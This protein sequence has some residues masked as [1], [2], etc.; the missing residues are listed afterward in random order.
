MAAHGGQRAQPRD[1]QPADNHAD[2]PAANGAE[3]CPLR[4]QHVGE[5]AVRSAYL[6]RVRRDDAHRAASVR[7]DRWVPPSGSCPCCGDRARYSTAVL[8]SSIYASSKLARCAAS[9]VKGMPASDMIV[10]MRSGER[11]EIVSTSGPE[12]AA[13]APALAN[14]VMAAASA[15]VLTVTRSAEAAAISA[16]TLESAITRPRPTTTSWSAVSSSS[17]IR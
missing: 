8:V 3:L 17:L 6:W 11:S 1:E 7:A 10:T 5:S 9:S 15:G 13:S 14:A 2:D 16:A 4:T 12:L